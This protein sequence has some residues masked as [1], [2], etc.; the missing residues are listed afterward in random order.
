MGSEASGALARE[1]GATPPAGVLDA[2]DDAELQVLTDAIHAARRRQAAMLRAA[3]DAALGHLPWIVR[4][5][6]KRV[7]GG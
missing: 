2:L 4:G 3:G 1:L 5:A 6:V 7:V